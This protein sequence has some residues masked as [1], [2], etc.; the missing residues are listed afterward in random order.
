MGGLGGASISPVLTATATFRSRCFLP[1]T[2]AD[3]DPLPLGS[4][5]GIPAAA[6][7][8]RPGSPS[9]PPQPAAAG[10]TDMQAAAAAAGGR[11]QFG[12][13]VLCWWGCPR[14]KVAG[15][16][17]ASALNPCRLTRP[18]LRVPTRGE[19]PLAEVR[20]RFSAHFSPGN[21]PDKPPGDFSPLHLSTVDKDFV[22]RLK[23]DL[24]VYR[25]CSGYSLQTYYR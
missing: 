3:F 14:A 23:L 8:H 9:P 7:P 5:C 16:R 12:P 11:A 18:D 21:L 22:A 10:V 25:L 24:N 13:G 20:A 4:H 19:R 2:R 1:H 6:G 15:G 17:G